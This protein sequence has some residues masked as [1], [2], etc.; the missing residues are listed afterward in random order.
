MQVKLHKAGSREI[1]IGNSRLRTVAAAVAAA[2]KTVEV[3]AAGLQYVALRQACLPARQAQHL[4]IIEKG[5]CDHVPLSHS[6][7]NRVFLDNLI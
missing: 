3:A 6:L 5:A 7:Y 2:G 4:I 1:A